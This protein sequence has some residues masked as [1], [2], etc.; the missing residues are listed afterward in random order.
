M[1]TYLAAVVAVLVW[2]LA[3]D[4]FLSGMLIGST[5]AQLP[6]LVA[7]VSKLWETVGDLFA[8]IML[9]GVYA[10]VRGV[11]GVGAKN[12]AIY[13]VYAGLLINFPTWLF[14]TVYA[15]WPYSLTW[16]M[17]LAGTLLTVV[18]GAIIG[19]VYQA[20]SARRRPEVE[21]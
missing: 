15:G 17:T 13:G 21:R 1:K 20:M 12:G 14:M 2:Y 5:M 10:R 3:W 18:A 19:Q 4:N 9:T 11:Y 8:A 7:E 6:G 16:T